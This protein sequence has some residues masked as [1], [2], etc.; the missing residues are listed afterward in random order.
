MNW[1]TSKENCRRKGL[2]TALGSSEVLPH[3]SS[4][5]DVCGSS[6]PSRLALEHLGSTSVV[7]QKRRALVRRV[8]KEL[9]FKLV[10]ALVEE[11]AAYIEQHPKYKF[12]GEEFVCS[13]SMINTIASQAQ[14]IRSAEDL[15]DQLAL[16][17]DLRDR[18]YTVLMQCMC[19]APAAKRHH[20]APVSCRV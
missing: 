12:I 9:Q 4:C 7:R 6:P 5:C 19:D 13:K 18:F 11:R 10:S 17:R 3:T 20:R 1:C 14:Y 16:R 2:L 15:G 8:D